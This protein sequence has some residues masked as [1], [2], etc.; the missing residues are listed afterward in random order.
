MEKAILLIAAMLYS[1]DKDEVYDEL[2]EAVESD[3]ADLKTGDYDDLFTDEDLQ[4]LRED[5]AK[6][7]K[8]LSIIK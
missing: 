7:E 2:Q 6:I 1:I 5:I 4:Y 8:Y 3:I